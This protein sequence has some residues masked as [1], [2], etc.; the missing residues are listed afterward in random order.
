[1]VTFNQSIVKFLLAL[2]L[3]ISKP[4][5]RHILS[6][7]HGI[8]LCDGRK[9]VSQIRRMTNDYRDLSCMTRFLNESPWCPNRA[10]RRRI[11]FMMKQVKRARAKKGDDRPLTFF[12]VDDSQCKKDRSTKRMER[13]DDHF[14]HSDGKT[15]WSHCVVTAHVVS[16]EYSFAFDFRPYFRESYCQEH[17][18]PFKSKVDLAIELIQSFQ[19]DD[20]EQVYV[21][22][23]S[24]YP[25]KKLIDACNQKGF[26]VISAVRSNRKMYPK[27]IGIKANAFASQY[28]EASDLRSVTVEG[29]DYKVYTYEGPLSDIENAKV[30]LSWEKRFDVSQTPFCILC[31]DTSLNVVT[32]LRYY[33]AR[34]H[35]ETGYRYF[36]DLLGFDQYQML[37][38]KHSAVL[39]YS[40]FGLQFP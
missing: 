13:L 14:S 10:T 12:I 34:W 22:T 27:G 3:Q 11:Q 31:T 23:D 37:S 15:V 17:G 26:H 4:Q 16:E 33:N 2:G 8:I 24:W 20:D 1:M 30:L 38:Y 6:F 21:L 39:V 9:T 28:I 5:R 29:H 25:S 32:I 18:L 35:I 40:V 7:M 36:K 19:A